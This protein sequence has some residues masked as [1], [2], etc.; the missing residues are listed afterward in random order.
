MTTDQ[1]ILDM[2][3]EGGREEAFRLLVQ[4]YKERL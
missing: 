1:K 4:S 2:Y 3:R